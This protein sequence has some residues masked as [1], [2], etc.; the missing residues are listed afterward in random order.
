[1]EQVAI[2][3]TRSAD[4]E[5]PTKRYSHF[6]DARIPGWPLELSEFLWTLDLQ[7]V[8]ERLFLP[9]F[10]LWMEFAVWLWLWQRNEL[11]VGY[12]SS[13]VLTTESDWHRNWYR[14][15]NGNRLEQR[16]SDVRIGENAQA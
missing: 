5:P 11:V 4:C 14:R 15:R 2:E 8:H 3:N 1:M 10:W 13:D 12:E 7:P 16:N 6:V 9:A